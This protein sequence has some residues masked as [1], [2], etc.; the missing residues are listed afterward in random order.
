M[1]GNRTLRYKYPAVITIA[2]SD[3]GGGAGIQA[4]LKTFAALGCY[5]SSAITAVTV[6][7]TLGVQA[8]HS[9]PAEIVEG[10]IRA[11]MDDIKPAAVK[12]GM[13][14]TPEL[15]SII[16]ETLRNYP[17]VPVIFDPVMVSTSGH[18]LILDDTI[19]ALK[20]GLIVSADLLTP[21]L[22][23]AVLLCGKRIKSLEDMLEAAKL[24]IGFGCKA[25]LLKGGHLNGPIMYDVYVSAE[26]FSTV[27]NAAHIQTRNTHGTGC[28]LSAAIAAKFALGY[29]MIPA[30]ESAKS[31]LSSALEH[32]RDVQTGA[33][34]G[35]LNHFFKPEQQQK[36][37]FH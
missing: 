21:N 28:T 1:T 14:H 20:A 15:A 13:V 29:S 26:G 36:L 5:G 10:Q 17:G 12:V 24:L 31:Y 2:G 8:I 11:V 19:A 33:G 9:I 4:D 16:N 7:N 30:I 32:G 6:Q 37:D 3:S 34:S 27:F 23:E 25:V 22:D 18:K 35:P